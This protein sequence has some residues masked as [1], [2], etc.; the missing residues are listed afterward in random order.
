M[1]IKS[2][3]LHEFEPS[4]YIYICPWLCSS[5]FA[6]PDE[7]IDAVTLDRSTAQ[8]LNNQQPSPLLPLVFFLFFTPFS[9]PC[10]GSAV[11]STEAGV[12]SV[13]GSL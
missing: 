7:L 3:P 13:S 9:P 4:V 1:I 8:Q 6:N 11:A 12:F 5:C 10:L 2:F